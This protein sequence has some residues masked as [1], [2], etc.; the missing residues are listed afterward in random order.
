MWRQLA[1][2]TDDTLAE[3]V[4]EAMV[5]CGALAV[6]FEDAGDQPLFEPKPGEVP[7]WSQTRVI[8]LFPAEVDVAAI[9]Q[10]LKV[11]FGHRLTGWR[12]EAV[13]DRPWERVW[14]EYF[15]PVRYGRRLWICPTGFAVPDADAVIVTLDPGLAF[16]TGSHP[17][18]ALC[19]EWLDAAPD[20]QGARLIDYGCG[21]G[22]LA[23]AALMLG[24]KAA[25]ALDID[26]QALVATVENARR[27]AVDDRL[28][29]GQPA[30]LRSF[31][32]D[33]LVANILASPLI[34]LAPE[35]SG[36]IRIGGHLVLSG[37]LAE[38]AADVGDAYRTW[39]D[40]LKHTEM[41]GWVRLDGVRR[42]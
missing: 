10:D 15:Q 41:D 17:T 1:I 14:L 42:R 18:T 32:A 24:A 2:V 3:S 26:P 11:Q 38:Q 23:I 22:I 37:I 28:R 9:A 34:E 33:I 40:V 39:F 29:C 35:L 16:G 13:E 6:S 5:E 21:S 27:N 20:L 31:E 4:S 12:T 30:E 25:D 7:V 19:L 8:A 36:R